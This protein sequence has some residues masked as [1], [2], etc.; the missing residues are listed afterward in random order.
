MNIVSLVLIALCF[1]MLVTMMGV[2]FAELLL[3]SI[4]TKPTIDKIVYTWTDKV[5][6]TIL[7]PKYNLDD[8]KIDEIGNT[9]Q[10]PVK[11]STKH[12]ELDQYKLVETGPDT[13]VFAGEVTLTGFKHDAD[14]DKKT[15]DEN[16]YDTCP[17]TGDGN[18]R[19]EPMDEWGRYQ[20][21]QASDGNGTT[22]GLG[23]TNGFL[24]NTNDDTITISFKFSEDETIVK[25]VPIK[26][27]IGKVQWLQES[28][29]PDSPGRLRIIDPD[30]N[31]DPESIDS[32]EVDVWSTSDTGGLD[33][34]V[35]ETGNATGIFEGRIGVQRYTNYGY[36][37]GVSEADVIT[38]EYEDNTLPQPHD[39]SDKL[40]VEDTHLVLKDPL[41]YATITSLK[42]SG[43]DSKES[44]SE[45]SSGKV[46]TITVNIKNDQ[47]KLRQFSRIIQIEN[48]N[49]EVVY[50]LEGK[51][52]LHPSDDTSSS[53]LWIPDTP[54]MYTVTALMWRS[55]DNP[56]PLSPT[57]KITVFVTPTH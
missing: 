32:F 14:G 39:V 15:G 28:N 41:N 12:H 47:Q 56:V 53:V 16:G 36:L 40:Y 48:A 19:F 38:A 43:D 31:L 22:V 49:N 8:E 35:T 25:S 57:A 52:S 9:V 23:P 33:V 54:G 34:T 17:H 55:M 13:S 30:M 24:E 10:N 45:V 37:L 20:C 6:I 42:I 46:A 4:T 44:V 29:Y 27:N 7:A 21:S 26:W 50:L 2:S 1:T 11:I 51:K 3:S 18:G 5:H